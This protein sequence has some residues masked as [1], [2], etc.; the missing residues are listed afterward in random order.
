[1][2]KIRNVTRLI[3]ACFSAVAA[4][5]L[6]T[7]II[8]LISDYKINTLLNTNID[9]FTLGFMLL[10]LIFFS[11]ISYFLFKFVFKNK[12]ENNKN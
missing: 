11:A 12:S 4:I 9:G 7:A 3:L 6:L 8:Y 5:S 1:M 2:T 10:S